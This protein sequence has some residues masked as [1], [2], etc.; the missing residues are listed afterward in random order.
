MILF[1]KRKKKDLSTLT[2]M[3]KTQVAELRSI[4][5]LTKPEEVYV[6]LTL[7]NYQ[8]SLNNA[9]ALLF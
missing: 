7:K 1:Q 3:D 8:L 2:K 9:L 5:I 6:S 4:T